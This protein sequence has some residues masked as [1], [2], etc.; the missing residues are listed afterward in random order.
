MD[1]SNRSGQQ[2]IPPGQYKTDKWPVLTY[3]E[4]PELDLESFELRIFGTPPMATPGVRIL[5]ALKK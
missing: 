2:R 5:S 4:P 3:G 1:D